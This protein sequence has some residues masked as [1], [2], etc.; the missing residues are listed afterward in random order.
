LTFFFS[1]FLGVSRQ[2]EFKNTTNIILQKVHVENFS[3]KNRQKF[4][5]QFPLDFFCFIAFSGVSQ[6]WEFKNKQK[7]VLQKTSCQK[8]LTKNS[9]KNPKNEIFSIFFNHVFG[10]FSV[11][12]V[13]KHDKNNIK[14]INLTPSLFSFSYSD[15]PTTGVTDLFFCAGPLT[16]GDEIELC[17]V[18]CQRT[19]LTAGSSWLDSSWLDSS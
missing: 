4:R 9:T 7:N 2:G 1:A 14:K 15:P 8:V 11:R 19:G 6:R 12:G 16:P 18:S 5:C 13:Q 17:A 10:R 3:Q